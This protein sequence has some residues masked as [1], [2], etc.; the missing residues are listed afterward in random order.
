LADSLVLLRFVLFCG[1]LEH[2]DLGNCNGDVVFGCVYR[3]Y[4]GLP[5]IGSYSVFVVGN[6]SYFIMDGHHHTS[7]CASCEIVD[8]HRVLRRFVH[9]YEDL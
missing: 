7:R 8:I 1:P 9:Q 3:W 2:C 5:P 4:L 6:S